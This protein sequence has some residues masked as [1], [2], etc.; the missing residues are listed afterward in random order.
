[1]GL[2]LSSLRK[3]VSSLEQALVI[4]D[5]PASQFDEKTLEVI[6]AGVI[7]N[8]EFTYELSHKT[9]RRYLEM[10]AA[11][12]SSVDEMDF[13]DLIRTANEQALL[14][15]DWP[16]WKDYRK[17]RGITSHTYDETK[18]SAVMA[19]IPGFLQESRYLLAELEKRN[20]ETD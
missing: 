12:P 15:S 14:L 7:Q 11:T 18:A 19:R 13:A 16:V 17:A 9:L 8:F 10:T 1:M 3:A 5:N 4:F 6:R 2:D 20:R